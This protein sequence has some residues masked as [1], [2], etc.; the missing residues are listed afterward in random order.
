MTVSKFREK[1]IDVLK[2]HALT[3]AFAWS[4][5]FGI[6]LGIILASLKDDNG[7][8]VWTS[9]QLLA[10]KWIGDMAGN[11]TRIIVVP[12]VLTS[13][14]TVTGSAKFSLSLKLMLRSGLTLA[15]LGFIVLIAGS[16]LAVVL[17]P[18]TNRRPL[19]PATFTP[20]N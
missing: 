14:V 3:F 8:N 7:S 12:L 13:A 20:E 16:L 1:L 10:L 11:L 19:T 4:A 6:V 9:R 15:G 5:L 18:G 17:K 2:E